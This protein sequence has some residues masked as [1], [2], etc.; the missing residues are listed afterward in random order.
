MVGLAAVTAYHNSFHGPFVYDDVPAIV[1][2]PTIRQLL[3]IAPV[4]SPPHN[5]ET[6]SGRPLLNFT[7]A[8]NYAISGLNVWSYHV[9]NL[10]IHVAAALLLFGILRRTFL[11]P[12]L[13]DCFG[14]A[15]TP[16]AAASA[17]LWAVHPL[18][19]ESVTYI[20]QRAESLAGCFYLLT[21]Y[22]VIRGAAPGTVPIFARA[23]MGLSPSASVKASSK[24]TVP[25]FAEYGPEQSGSVGGEKGDSPRAN[26]GPWLCYAAAV[27][28]CLLG[29]ACKEILVTAPLMVLLYDRTFLVGSFAEALRRRWGLYVGLA[30]I[31]GLSAYLVLST[32]LIGRQAEMG[33]PDAW[34]YARSQPGVIL[35]YLRLSFWP[36]PLCFDYAWPVANT[37][38][39]IFPG[40]MVVCLLLAATLWGMARRQAWSFL[41]AWFLLILAPTSSILPLG[42]LA[43]EHRMYLSLAAVAV[44]S[45]AGGYALWDGWLPRAAVSGRGATVARWAAPTAL[46]A[47]ALLALG[48]ATVARNRDYRSMLAIYQDTVDKRPQNPV[49]RNNLGFAL[50]KLE[51]TVEAIPQ[52]REAL[53]L[54][55]DYAEA[56]NNLGT[57][58]AKLGK[59]EEAIEHFLAALRGKPEFAMAYNNLGL[60]LVDLGRTD[61]ALAHYRQALRL[62][63][64]DADVHYNLGIAVAA[65]GKTSQAIQHYQRALRLKPDYVKAHNNL[66]T[67][68]ASLGRTKEAIEHYRQALRLKPDEA[69]AHSNLGNALVSL[70]AMDEAVEH[71]R[72]ALRLKPDFADAHYNLGNARAGLGRTDEAIASF[73]EALRL[74]PDYTDAHNNLAA[75]LAQAGK[76][77][78]AIE[79]CCEAVRLKPDY[80]QAHFNLAI[81]LTV[82]GRTEEAIEQYRQAVRLKPDYWEAYRNLGVLLA[83]LGNTAEAI[84]H[85]RQAVQ[86]KP[87]DAEAHH[88]LGTALDQAGKT[89]EAISQYR[90]A[91]RLRPDYAEAHYNLAIALAAAGRLAEA[92]E[93]YREALRLKPDYLEA[94]N[95]LGNAL[96]TVG[97]VAEA[98]EHYHEVL[99][100]KPDYAEA[101]YN[102]G[103]ALAALGRANEA[104]DHLYQAVRL[105]PDFAMARGKLAN[106]L[107]SVGRNNESIEQYHQALQLMPDSLETVNNL[108]WLLASCEPAEGGDPARAVQ[109]AERA[110]E[111]A[112]QENAQVLDTLAAAYAAVGRF[113][114]AVVAAERAVQLAES[115]GQTA[116]AKSIQLRLELYRAGRPYRQPPRS[117]QQTGP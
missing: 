105:K 36:R 38:W 6:V 8:I 78:E 28:A 92:I 16:L 19:T 90:E 17:A 107:A 53:R 20:V 21:L 95:N 77:D 68:L 12:T 89:D 29:T 99:R 80:A 49:A 63:P 96:F 72:E 100:L 87:A 66:G 40:A 60:A 43:F 93:H 45:V 59:P 73:R 5:G 46:W 10:A 114:E 81:A 7:L 97:R 82:Q 30:A 13:R 85:D 18:H 54:N 94:H 52:Y 116:L 109:L 75:A 62:K 76:I 33:A 106:V 47:A 57:A 56:H 67:A 41:G 23:K 55:A 37:F 103:M 27:L 22:G 58:L 69:A 108:A 44:L 74:K 70:G 79:H 25:F 32:G 98:I 102:L 48:Y 112:G 91:L 3:P 64:D 86:L 35:H 104:I 31:W 34:G 117:S 88:N 115:A 15:A 111:L 51:K 113:P 65:L 83:R 11:S 110:R 24:G 39:E 2:N 1:E 9:T 26:V 84:E 71:F 61:E 42:Q 4:L 50:V 101:Y 14:T